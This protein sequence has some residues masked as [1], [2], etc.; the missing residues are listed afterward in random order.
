MAES[1][2]VNGGYEVVH[3]ISLGDEAW[4]QAS[5]VDNLRDATSALAEARRQINRATD[6][7]SHSVG[8]L[9]AGWPAAHSLHDRA[10]P[11]SQ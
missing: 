4:A 6:L 10:A 7:L 5:P 9:I 11:E 8:K 3:A 2:T 1:D